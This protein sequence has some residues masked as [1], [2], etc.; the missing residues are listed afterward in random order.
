MQPPAAHEHAPAPASAAAE[1]A[2]DASWPVVAEWRKATR[3]RLLGARYA[4]RRTERRRH[5]AAVAR[6]LAALGAELDGR[7]VGFYWPLKGEIDLVPFMRGK[8]PELAAAAL[9]VIVEKNR[10]LEFWAWTAR[11]V[12]CSRGLWNI[13]AP[14]ERVLVEPEVLLVPLLGFDAAG[15]RLGYGGGY[16]DRTLGDRTLGDRT[17]GDRTPGERT[18]GDSTPTGRPRPRLI[19]VGYEMGR[20]ATIYPQPHDV[21]MDTIVTEQGRW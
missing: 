11:T 6:T 4:L 8:L 15:H 17:V 19:G 21:P 16:Y 18:L 5:A 20:L 7:R 13:P 1:I 3:T 10:P 9:P 14:A 2:H 12:L